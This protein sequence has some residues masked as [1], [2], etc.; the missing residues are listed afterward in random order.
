MTLRLPRALTLMLL[1]M[2]ITPAWGQAS[3]YPSKMIKL[4]VPLPP[5]GASDNAARLLADHLS[6]VWKQSVLV[7]NRPG[8]NG[9]IAATSVA[10]AKA[11]GYTLLFS[12]PSMA[13]FKAF[14]KNPPVDIE[15]DFEPVSLIV[16]KGYYV[17][18]NASLPVNSVADLVK[19]AKAHPGKL[20]Y[21]AFGGGNTLAV[22][23]FKQMTGADIMRVEYRGEAAT[24]TALAA[25]EVQLSFGS[26]LAAQ[27][28]IDTGKVKVL[29]VTTAK[30]GA[31]LPDLPT[32]AE[33]GLSGYEALVWYGLFAPANTPKDIVDKLS[34][35]IAVFLKKPD[36]VSRFRNLEYTARGTTPAEFRSL[37]ESEVKRWTGVASK[38]ALEKQ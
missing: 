20:N 29:A 12:V 21:G 11:D 34:K 32:L 17:L 22:E 25:N 23:M 18:V 38:L 36:I 7:E 27:G 13:T 14:L 9:V 15:K 28:F 1:A 31:A 4:V 33:S 3:D 2:L 26:K 37:V 5:G 6:T 10:Q 8:G 30:R 16:D 24:A 35:E 19:Y